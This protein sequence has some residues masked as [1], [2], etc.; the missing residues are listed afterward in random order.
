MGDRVLGVFS[1]ISIPPPVAFGLKMGAL[2]D[3]HNFG[4]GSGALLTP[5]HGICQI[6]QTR[7]IAGPTNPYTNIRTADVFQN[8]ESGR[9]LA[10]TRTYYNAWS[11]RTDRSFLSM[12]ESGGQGTGQAT[13][14]AYGDTWDLTAD[15]IL[16]NTPNII[17]VMETADNFNRGVGEE[18]EEAG[19]D[20]GAHN[21]ELRERIAARNLPDQIFICETARDITLL[22]AEIGAS[23]VFWQPNE[24]N[25]YHFKSVGNLMIA[26]GHFKA[27][28]YHD[29]VLADLADIGTGVVSSDWQQVCL[30]IYNA[31]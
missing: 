31:N 23:N 28:R 10:G 9:T 2:G 13:P 8:G 19:R 20:W 6:M 26:L 21:D 5:Y 14:T 24:S 3:S 22:E 30:D 11:G 16:S 17:W 18:F 25:P 7:G 4:Y 12:Q 1:S 29:I 15:D 27:M